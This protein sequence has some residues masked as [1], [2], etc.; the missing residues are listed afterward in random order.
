MLCKNQL[1]K[2]SLKLA[3]CFL[4]EELGD[5][6]SSGTDEDGEMFQD[7]RDKVSPCSSNSDTE[8]RESDKHLFVLSEAG[9]PIYT[10]HGDEEILV[11]LF[12]VMQ[13]GSGNVLFSP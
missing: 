1:I 6:L 3:V 10:L 2:I 7:A 11:S 8:W 4:K 5:A 9:K 13:V 12:G